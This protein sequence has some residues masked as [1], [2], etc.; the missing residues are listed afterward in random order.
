MKF[1]LLTA[2]VSAL[3]AL[4]AVAEVN[5]VRV[6]RQYTLPYLAVMVMED[7]KLLEKQ[8]KARGIEVTG[9]WSVVSSPAAVNDALLSGNLDFACAGINAFLTI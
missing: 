9:K 8:G 3:L 7:Q 4:P 6:F 1:R 2:L 5:E